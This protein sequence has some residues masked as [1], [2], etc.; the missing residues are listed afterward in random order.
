[1][2][3]PPT[4]NTYNFAPGIGE[5]GLNALSRIQIRPPAITN[6]H[7]IAMR[8]EGN[9]LQAEWSNKGV[10]LWTVDQQTQALTQ[11]T[12]T[13]NVPANTIMI[14]DA[15]ISTGSP[16]TNRYITPFSRTDFASLGNPTSQGFPTTFWFDRLIAPSL[17][18]WPVPDGGGPYTLNYYRY[19]QIQDA[20]YVGGLNAEIPYTFLDAWSA[21]LAHRLSRHYA[22]SLEQIRKAD[23]MEAFA[24]ASAQNVEN[25][26]VYIQP[27]I[28]NYYRP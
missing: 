28:S 15:Y 17:T 26:P 9:F 18:L 27:M 19:R 21:G 10:T 24:I 1:M 14:L 20:E 5:L 7:M 8:L 16:A 13:Y 12:A 11:G 4:S 23:A 6:D 2:T 3:S 22:P 25:V